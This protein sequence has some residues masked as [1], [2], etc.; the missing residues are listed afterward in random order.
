MQQQLSFSTPLTA[1]GSRL[2]RLPSTRYQGSKRKFA[3]ELHECF[4]AL[5]PR[6]ALDLF[7]GSGIVSLLLRHCGAQVHAND[8]LL[9]NQGVAR[10][11]LNFQKGSFASVDHRQNL[12]WLIEEA[13]LHLPGLVETHYSGIFFPDI[14]NRQIDRFAQNIDGFDGLLKDLYVYAY[15]QALLKKRPYNLFHRANLQM[16]TKDVKRSFGNAVTWETPAVEH[17]LKAI[18]ELEA[19]PWSSQRQDHQSTG[20][21]DPSSSDFGSYDLV[22]L[23]PPY[24]N[25]KGQG[26]DYANFY[27]FLDGLWDYELFNKGD[28]RYA[29]KPICPSTSV[30]T[31]AYGVLSGF[32]QIAERFKEETF[33]ISYRTDGSPSI[34][35]ILDVLQLKERHSVIWGQKDYKYALSDESGTKECLIVSRPE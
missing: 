21:T 27:G 14:E 18:A 28:L 34:Q 9:Y 31:S 6:R 26:T 30:W 4:R 10:L 15:G 35:E 32:E 7:S 22:Y 23:D 2:P 33:V 25:A 24:V 29:H 20:A 17:A 1:S 3:P 19:F 16:R 13:P 8:Y 5:A 11:F 12:R